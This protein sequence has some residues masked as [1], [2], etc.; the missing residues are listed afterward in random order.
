MSV[1]YRLAQR[2][3][4]PVIHALLSEN[5]ANDG[6]QLQGSEAA[7][8]RHGFGPAPMFRVALAGRGGDVLGLALFFP[9]YSS[10][11][12]RMGVSIQD[13]YVRPT[14][15]GLGVGRGLL[16]CAFRAAADWQPAFMTLM[17]Q[18]K[19]AKAQGFYASQGFTLRE[20]ADVLICEGKALS[21]L[22][23]P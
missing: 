21:R 18:H 19:N 4:V 1:A 16:A 8:L 9:E 10:W 20:A 6:A 7:L 13:L 14:A 11:R 2:A 3:D 15:R 23:A 5:A 22:V 17:V 12:G